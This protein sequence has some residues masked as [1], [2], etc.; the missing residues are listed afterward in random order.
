VMFTEFLVEHN[1]PLSVSDHASKLFKKMFPDS[2]I[3][4][5]YGCAR[6]KTTAVVDCLATDDQK[7]IIKFMQTQPFSLAT[8]A[9]NDYEDVK[10]FPI[11]V[12]L[13]NGNGQIVSVLLEIKELNKS[14]SGENIFGVLDDALK[15]HKIPWKNCVSF[16][17]DNASVMTGRHK[18]VASY[19]HKVN[20]SVYINGCVCHLMHLAADKAAATTAFATANKNIHSLVSKG[21]LKKSTAARKVSRLHKMVNKIEA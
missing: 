19:I 12:R 2:K 1:C 4:E 17:C 11:C 16:S 18:G 9:S 6:T 20:S 21:F 5:Q 15:V 7:Q 8:D 13:L 14:A 3:A 10:L